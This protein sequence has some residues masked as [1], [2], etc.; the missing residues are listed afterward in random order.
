V[1]L[2]GKSVI[3]EGSLFRVARLEDE[4]HEDVVDP[5]VLVAELQQAMVN[6]DLF[7]FW[8]RLPDTEPR[9]PYFMIPDPIA[10]LPI[11]TY[12]AWLKNQINNK[13]RN[14]IGK[15]HK[16]GVVIKPA[17]FDDDFIRGMMAIFNETPVRQGVPFWH[18]GKDFETLKREFS[19]YLFREEI[20]GAYLNGELIGFIFIVNAGSFAMLGQII[21]MLRHRDKAINNALLAKAVEV[22]A[23]RRFRSLV[24]AIWPRGPLKEFKRH[25]GFERVDL[26]RYYVPLTAKGTLY[27]KLGLHRSLSDRLPD[28]TFL[29]IRNARSRFYAWRY[30]DGLVA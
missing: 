14:M 2:A 13:T 26:P 3:T 6:A 30:R 29:L 11:T 8:Q 17:T 20:H 24:Y 12:E 7:T 10:D 18:Y 9:F 23:Q 25:N 27:L 16:K 4:W 21:S 15:A 19:R 28:S 22:C 5:A 1:K